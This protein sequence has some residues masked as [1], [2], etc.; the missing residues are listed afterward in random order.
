MLDLAEPLN[1]C[2][3]QQREGHPR[4]ISTCWTALQECLLPL[5]EKRATQLEEVPPPRLVMAHAVASPITYAPLPVYHHI[6]C[7]VSVLVHEALACLCDM[8]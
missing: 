8:W 7:F 2:R 6:A 3:A 1:V 5:G 4:A